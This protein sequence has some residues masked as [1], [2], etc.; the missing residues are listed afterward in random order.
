[1]RALILLL[2]LLLIPARPPQLTA[3][4]LDA[5]HALIEWQSDAHTVCLWRVPAGQSWG[6]FLGCY[7]ASERMVLP[8]DPPADAA[9]WPAAGDRYV[10]WF[11]DTRVEAVLGPRGWAVY[12][13]RV[14]VA[15]AA[16]W[17]VW[18]PVITTLAG[19]G[20][21]VADTA[22]ASVVRSRP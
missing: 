17:R 13:P 16:A 22:A 8:G 21:S 1:M 9:Y 14:E 6:Y 15:R 3:R 5:T 7:G 12:L 4:W 2:A 20:H 11:D 10:G 18:L 19:A